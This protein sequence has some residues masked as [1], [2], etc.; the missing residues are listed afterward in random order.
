LADIDVSHTEIIVRIDQLSLMRT[1]GRGFVEAGQHEGCS[2]LLC[3]VSDDG[4]EW[5]PLDEGLKTAPP[6][7]AV[8]T[9]ESRDGRVGSM[10]LKKSLMR[11]GWLDL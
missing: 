9:G 1:G 4:P 10:L 7:L 6:Q 8:I 5:Q 3:R 2:G 11:L